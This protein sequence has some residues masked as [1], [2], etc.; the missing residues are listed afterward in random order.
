M[1]LHRTISKSNFCNYARN[2]SVYSG[3][4]IHDK[5]YFLSIYDRHFTVR[6]NSRDYTFT[7]VS[8]RKFISYN[9]TMNLDESDSYCIY[10]FIVFRIHLYRFKTICCYILWEFLV[11]NITIHGLIVFVYNLLRFMCP[12]IIRCFDILRN[13]WTQIFL[14]HNIRYISI[15]YIVW[16]FKMLFYCKFCYILTL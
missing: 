7:S 9:K 13:L 6:Q 15:I 14:D 4:W 2:F 3:V 8:V 1:N 16:N 5:L 12:S 10:C 11:H